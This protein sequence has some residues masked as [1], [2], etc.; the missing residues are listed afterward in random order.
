MIADEHFAH[1][2]EEEHEAALEALNKRQRYAALVQEVQFGGSSPTRTALDGS[3]HSP[4]ELAAS[5]SASELPL[6]IDWAQIHKLTAHAELRAA[7]VAE[8]EADAHAARGYVDADA[9]ARF[10]RQTE[11]SDAIIASIKAKLALNAALPDV[12][13]RGALLGGGA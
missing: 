6:L 10:D 9:F 11:L 5:S 13:A 7:D 8:L 3:A 12:G 4:H 2:F 1:R